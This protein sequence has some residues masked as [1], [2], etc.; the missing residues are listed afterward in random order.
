MKKLAYEIMPYSISGYIGCS[1]FFLGLI[2]TG[3]VVIPFAYVVIKPDKLHH[4]ECPPQL[5]NRSEYVNGSCTFTLLSE[6]INNE[7]ISYV[8]DDSYCMEYPYD[9]DCMSP[10][11]VV[12]YYIKHVSPYYWRYADPITLSK[13]DCKYAHQAYKNNKFPAGLLYTLWIIGS[14]TLAFGLT[15]FCIGFIRHICVHG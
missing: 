9:C 15:M 14:V 3:L 13:S 4:Y 10:S 8:H 7:T 2:L 1:I 12:C 11:P 5:C 6:K